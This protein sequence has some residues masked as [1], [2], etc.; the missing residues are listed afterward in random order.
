MKHRPTAIAMIL[1]EQVIVEEGTH[2]VTP[3]NCFNLRELEAIPGNFSF[4]ALAWLAGGEGEAQAEILIQRL[5]NL[6]TI[7]RDQ[8]K[9][10][11]NHPLQD[12]RCL[13]RIRNC[14]FPVSGYFEVSL[15]IDRELIAHRRFRLQQKGAKS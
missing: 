3:V 7:Y 12:S 5:D 8:R 6:D 9:V 15:I 2:N 4:C 14:T 1:C 13:V 11:F 10:T